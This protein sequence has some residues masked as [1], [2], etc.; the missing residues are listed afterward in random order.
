MQLNRSD[1]HLL[2][3]KYC[4]AEKYNIKFM[5]HYIIGFIATIISLTTISCK[6]DAESCVSA[7]VVTN[8]SCIDSNLIDST[9]MCATVFEPVCGCDGVTYSN[10]C[11]ATIRGG[12]ISYV[13][14]KCCD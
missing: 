5:K 10:S 2:R 8:G 4:A 7:P 9:S 13:E 12:V 6:K 14:G 3:V 11:D 1:Q